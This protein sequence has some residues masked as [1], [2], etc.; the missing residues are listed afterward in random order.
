M[1]ENKFKQAETNSSEQGEHMPL[2]PSGKCESI[3][4]LAFGSLAV[5]WREACNQGRNLASAW[6]SARQYAGG[7]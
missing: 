6:L 4:V 5:A 7:R 2:D 1:S 3:T